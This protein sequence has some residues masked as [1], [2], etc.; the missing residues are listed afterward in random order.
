MTEEDFCK[1]ADAKT[2]E[3]PDVQTTETF[4]KVAKLCTQ[5]SYKKRPHLDEVDVDFKRKCI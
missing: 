3:H 4:L 1:T 5:K 2:K